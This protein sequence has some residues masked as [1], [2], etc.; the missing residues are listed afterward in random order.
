MAPSFLQDN[1]S[2]EMRP[3]ASRARTV[4][5]LC[6]PYFCLARYATSSSLRPSS[7]PMRTLLQARYSQVQKKRDMEQAVCQVSG[8]PPEHCFYIG[9]I[10]IL[11]LDDCTYRLSYRYVHDKLT[12]EAVIVSCA[13][14]PISSL[15]GESIT[16]VPNPTESSTT[17]SQN[18]LIYTKNSLLWSLP[19][20]ECQDWFVC[21]H[22]PRAIRCAHTD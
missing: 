12:L 1:I 22:Y 9:Q 10:W 4:S 8:T 6:V 17:L 14:S 20:N 15:Q 11:I 2:G 5:W 19:V 16:I 13:Q 3:K 18:I 21:N 7:H